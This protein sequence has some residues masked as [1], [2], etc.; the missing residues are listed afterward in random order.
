MLRLYLCED[1]KE[2][3][4]QLL[5]EV[6]AR[7]ARAEHG[8][9]VIVPEQFSYE[10][11]RAL[12][13]AG[14]DSIS[15]FAEVLSFSRLAS[16]VFAACGGIAAASMDAGGRLTAMAYT[17]EQ[18]KSRLKIFG[19]AASKPESLAALLDTVDE[20]KSFCVTPQQLRAAAAQLTGAFAVKV[21]ELALIMESYDATCANSA[22]DP[23]T[24]YMRLRDA[25]ARSDYAADKQFFFDGFSDFNG[26]EYEI[27][28]Q[29]VCGAQTVTAYFHCDTPKN[30]LPVFAPARESVKKWIRL[31]ARN[32]IP[33][34]VQ[35]LQPHGADT[36]LRRVPQ[37]LFD[38]AAQGEEEAAALQLLR[39]QDVYTE[40]RNA[41]IEIKRAAC[42]GMRY[43]EISVLYTEESVYRP[44]LETYFRHGEIPAYFSGKADVLQNPV[45]RMLLAALRAAAYGME[46]EDVFAFLKS[47]FAPLEADRGARM[48][49]Y[50][51]LWNISGRAWEKPWTMNPAGMLQAMQE[52][53]RAELAKLNESRTAA[54]LPLLEL[55]DG[56]A[57]ADNTA[58]QILALYDFM[59]R[60]DLEGRLKEAV[61]SQTQCGDLRAAQEYAQ[62]YEIIL[63]AMEQLHGVLGQSVRTPEEFARLMR[64]MLSRYD[65]GSIP[66]AA[67]GV[68]VGTI[69]SG[70]QR[71][72]R[73]LIVLGAGEGS[74]P[75]CGAE[76]GL[77]ND[78]E[79]S[80][81]RRL[82]V[83]TAA[84][85]AGSID[86]AQLAICNVLQGASA[87]ICVS[88]G[89][90]APSY[91]F[92]R[93]ALLYPRSVSAPAA[94]RLLTAYDRR[95]AAR[96]LTQNSDAWADRLAKAAPL[97]ADEAGRLREKAG[98]ARGSLTEPTARALFGQ[99][100]RLSASKIDCCC[101]C[102][103][104]YF[105]Q[106]G[107]KA[108]ERKTAEFDAPIFGTFVHAVLEQTVR[109]VMQEGGFHRVTQERTLA[110]AAQAIDAFAAENAALFAEGGARFRYLFTRNQDEV[111]AIVRELYGELSVSEFE[112]QHFELGFG[113]G[114]ALPAITAEGS[115]ARC[116][117]TGFVDRVDLLRRGDK[118]YLRVVD[119]KTG[120]KDFDYTDLLE[121][122][123][124]QM[125]IYLFALQES[126]LGEPCGVLYFPARADILSEQARPSEQEVEKER[127]TK[128]RR[129]GVL[130]DDAAVLEAMEQS[131]AGPVYLP[132]RV[133]KSGER[134][135]DLASERQL[136]LLHRELRTT[137][138]ALADSIYGGDMRP[139]PYV[140]GVSSACAFCPYTAVCHRET[141]VQTVRSRRS[142]SAAEFWEEL[143]GRQSHG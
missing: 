133:L 80:E 19:T 124:L 90:S 26:L 66:A 16:R 74:F 1:W 23:S 107:L 35:T 97:L 13:K 98:F 120:R 132:Y 87:R 102:R 50:A 5:R 73:L 32:N 101:N 106:Y 96:Y 48:E 14:G 119:Y 116:E 33:S 68:F 78:L 11:E 24:R 39:A 17:L 3:R 93:L 114:Q 138:S 82:G 51:I 115:R 43:R 27:I 57:R 55:K 71:Q 136:N 25:L 125:F 44:V 45:V 21:D 122:V 49:N 38:T 30:G 139:E 52:R 88:C 40:C 36:A 20:L 54:I 112:P 34:Q 113:A 9:V 110:L 123:G 59:Q 128:L 41:V 2:N 86:R 10:T 76:R 100:I 7:A 18:I 22:Q 91:L 64:T 99:T 8:L 118:T 81:L 104:F 105:L 117:V 72:C 4:A 42:D 79:R 89:A 130:L 83:D 65:V 92:K 94:R 31:A 143:E 103:F 53:Q 47:G 37:R 137:L 134:Q 46:Q 111:L 75:A 61:A 84:G 141:E 12:C 60:I 77:L 140:R 62:I 70:R 63:G 28:E 142:V 58:Q 69:D 56:L 108:G 135:G 15:R 121:G 95:E 6:C 67:D 129:K 126:G 29:L 127:R 85:R 131:D 109:S